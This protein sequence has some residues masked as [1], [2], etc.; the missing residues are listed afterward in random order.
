MTSL[1]ELA[2]RLGRIDLE[3]VQRRALE[4]AAKRI[5]EAVRAALSHSPGG[6]HEAPWLQSGDL[7]D[8]IEH[9]ADATRAVIGSTS[10]V[11]V[12]QELGTRT[13]SPRPVLAP[14]GAAL[15]ES[16]AKAIGGAVAHAIRA[17]V[18]GKAR[19]I[20]QRYGASET[21]HEDNGCYSELID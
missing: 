9:E 19:A 7:R 4:D 15:G 1:A 8:S 16:V 12:Y 17:A 3:T 10:E 20:P 14:I 2:A 18:A 11:A 5:E 6:E 13:V 21:Q